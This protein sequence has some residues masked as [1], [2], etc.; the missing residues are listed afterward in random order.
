MKWRMF[1]NE[2]FSPRKIHLKTTPSSTVDILGVAVIVVFIVAVAAVLV[3][4]TK[5]YWRKFG[6]HFKT[7]K[8][9]TFTIF[10]P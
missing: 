4:G 2:S 6:S 1:C 8:K 3:T 5:V 7:V 9:W 10:E